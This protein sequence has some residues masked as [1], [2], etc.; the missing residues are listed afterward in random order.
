MQSPILKFLP[1]DVVSK[2][3]ERTQP[4]DGDLLFFGAD[5]A[6]I[7]NDAL[8]A[9]RVKLGIDSGLLEG[10]W[11]PLWVVDF[12]MFEWDE[13]ESRWNALHHPFTAPNFTQA[14]QLLDQPGESLSLAY[15]MVLNG[16][17]V[18]GGSVRIH[19]QDMQ[20]AVFDVLNISNEEAE[21]KFG[22]LLN[23]LKFGCPPHAGIAFGLDRLIM[24]MT[25]SESI[26]DVMAFP[27]TQTAQCPLTDAPAE[28]SERQLKELS[29][30]IRAKA[31]E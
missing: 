16:T 19:R 14:Q 28:V 23:A 11:Q 1:D 25:G 26:R 4:K 20:R 8:G 6:T 30:R 21:S 22:F 5:K 15:D 9:L 17:E 10:E 12:P 18:G 24:L 2:I 13:K 3:I 31:K 7:V 29:L 27:K